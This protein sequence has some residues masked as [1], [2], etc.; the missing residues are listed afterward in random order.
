MLACVPGEPDLPPSAAPAADRQTQPAD[1]RPDP[2]LA[3]E[4]HHLTASRAALA[5]MR[6][7][8]AGLSAQGGDGVSTE[9]L[10]A[11]LWHR[12]R[13]LGGR[14]GGAA[15]LRPHRPGRR[16]VVRGPAP[17]QR[18]QWRAVGERLASGHL[19][20]VLPGQCPCTDGCP[21]AAAVRLLPRGSHRVR[22]RVARRRA[23]A[24]GQ[25]PARGRGRAPTARTDARHRGHHPA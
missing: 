24:G 12:M 7:A 20:N 1:P 13:A 4:R 2:E 10:R 16:A 18:R 15:V 8:V 25:R 11:A 5:R 6:T 19:Q 21:A 3:A 9:Y 23:G 14:P 22:G 17:C